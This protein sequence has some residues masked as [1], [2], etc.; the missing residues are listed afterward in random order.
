MKAGAGSLVTLSDPR[1]PA[2]EAYRTLRTNLRFSSLETPPR[3]LLVVGSGIAEDSST[4]LCNLAVTMAQ[5]GTRVIVVDCDLRRPSI[6]KPFDLSND[7]GVTT[8]LMEET[9]DPPLQ[10]TAVP[11]LQVLAAGPIPPN[12]VDLIGSQR[13]EQLIDRLVASADLVMFN[14]APAG[15]VSDSS[16][17]ASKMDGTILV[18]GSG[19]TR[20]DVANRAKATLEKANTRILGIVLTNVHLDSSLAR[21]YNSQDR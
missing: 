8:T 12:P 16:L 5:S 6:H 18:V 1:S 21:Y 14:A 20:R 19:K 10:Q 13:M 9:P 15:M 4:V 3:T 7:K 11:S 2:A 17:L